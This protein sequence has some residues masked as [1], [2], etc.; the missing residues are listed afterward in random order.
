ML[1]IIPILVFVSVAVLILAFSHHSEAVEGRLQKY[2][3]GIASRRAGD[4]AKPFSQRVITPILNSLAKIG[5]SLTPKNLAQKTEEQLLLAGKPH[6]LT[7]GQF[8]TIANVG[9]ILLPALYLGTARLA[10]GRNPELKEFA[11]AAALFGLGAYM[12]PT[13]WLK[14]KISGRKKRI[15]KDLPDTLD[16]VTIC[17]EAGLTLEAALARVVSR[18]KGPLADE[19]RR[20]LQE[21]SIGKARSKALRDISLRTGVADLQSIIAALVQSEEIGSSIAS[22]LRVQADAMRIKRRQRAQEQAHQ[23]PVKMLFPL[24]LF[25]LPAMFTVILGPAVIR[26][27]SVFTLMR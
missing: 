13:L 16:L 18:T 7:S 23:A 22:V 2:G 20:A 9:G 3:Y 11:I 1:A 24:V 5:G 8:Q 19:F 6:G 14:S 4:L 27:I 26:L 21:V 15:E 17:V 10:S 12:L 25:I